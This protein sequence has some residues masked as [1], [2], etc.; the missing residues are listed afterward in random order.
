M[1]MGQRTASMD[2]PGNPGG[3]PGMDKYRARYQMA[4]GGAARSNPAQPMSVN[5]MGPT[6]KDRFNVGSQVGH[7]QDMAR[8]G[9]QGYGNMI[10]ADLQKSIGTMLGGMNSI[11]ALRSG[12][13]PVAAGDIMGQYGREVGNYASMA[14]RDAIG[15]GQEQASL[16]SERDYRARSDR[17]ARKGGLFGTLGKLAGG[18]AGSVLGPVG[19]AIGSRLAGAVIK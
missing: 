2:F 14:T 13:V 15:M 1:A 3:M 5:R 7:F 19:A 11:G 6:G 12:A 9:V 4:A 17:R 18:V 16:E 8:E 10:G